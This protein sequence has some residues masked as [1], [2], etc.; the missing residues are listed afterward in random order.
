M[1]CFSAELILTMTS[2]NK[3][4]Q[5][6]SNGHGGNGGS[7]QGKSTSPCGS[8]VNHV[9]LDDER[10][11]KE[12]YKFGDKLGSGAF[13]VVWLVTHLGTGQRYACKIINKEKVLSLSLDCL[14]CPHMWNRNKINSVLA[15]IY[16]ISAPSVRT[17]RAEIK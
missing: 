14:C 6:I 9:V 12:M 16:F 8:L 10:R 2:L 15:T 17:C 5:F 13:G 7:G 1:F 3:P 11:L 4:A